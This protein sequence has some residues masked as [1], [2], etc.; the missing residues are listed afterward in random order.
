MP[1]RLFLYNIIVLSLGVLTLPWIVYQLIF[2]KKRRQGL[3]QRFGGSPVMEQKA[4]WCHAVSVGEVR[5]V[6]P[7]LTLLQ[8]DM[9]AQDRLVLS[10]VTVTGQETAI[11]ECQFVSRIFYFPLDL[12]IVISRALRRV[13]PE[14]YITAETEIWPNF[15]AACFR[16]EIP[17]IVVNGRISDHSFS[18]YMRFRWFFNPIL[19]RVSLFLMQSEEDARRILALGAGPETV[20]VTGNMKYDRLPESVSLPNSLGKWAE[21]RFLLVA[22]STH[23][24]EEEA[25]LEV[26]KSLDGERMRLAIVP[27][28]P[29]RFA[30]VASLLKSSGISWELFSGIKP[31]KVPDADILLVDAMGVLDGF[32]AL[33][34]VA[35]VGGSLVPVGGHNLLE[36]AMHGIP[37]FTGPHLQNFR[38]IAEILSRF[39]G[40]RI[41]SDVEDFV[42]QLKPMLNDATDR[43]AMGKAA[44]AASRSAKGA[45]LKNTEAV[46]E[47]LDHTGS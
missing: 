35:F 46:L 36:P 38:D 8:N 19:Q 32:Y 9:R 33:A 11:R 47:V 6:T 15:F 7:M 41:V 20:M 12:P 42:Q 37:V 34:D 26:M 21:G 28:H 13:N 27:R 10:T 31:E 4:I 30:S 23:E 3:A 45:S 40:C 25:V 1:V 2:V 44:E 29:E 14:I 43:V 16:R 22:G 39:G 24:R 17:V 18:R 5:A